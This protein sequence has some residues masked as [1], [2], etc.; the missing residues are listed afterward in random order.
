MLY[1]LL[2]NTVWIRCEAGSI[3]LRKRLLAPNLIRHFHDASEFSLNQVHRH[4]PICRA[5]KIMARLRLRVNEEKRRIC[6][7]PS[8]TIPDYNEVRPD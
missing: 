4:D 2:P 3:R 6:K 5:F 1:A 7:I 8:D